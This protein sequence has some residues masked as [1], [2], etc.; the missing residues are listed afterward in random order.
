MGSRLSACFPT[1]TRTINN[2]L[3]KDKLLDNDVRDN[4][5][6]INDNLR[7]LETKMA[8]RRYEVDIALQYLGD[9]LDL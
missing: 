7:A 1:K 4:I 6:E 2:D 9:K 5:V 3:L 8:L